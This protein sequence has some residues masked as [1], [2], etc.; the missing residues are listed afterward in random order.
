MITGVDENNPL[1]SQEGFAP[2]GV[3]R[4]VADMREAI[5]LINSRIGIVA[6]IDSH[7]KSA[8]ENF[9]EQVL[10]TRIDDGRHGTGCFFGT[11]FGG[12]RGAGSGNPALD[13]DMV[14]GYLIWKTIYRSY[15]ELPPAN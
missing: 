6:C 12:D 13:E 9:I 5:E 7:D 11:K 15:D 4:S 14:N 1:Y 2:A 10:R 8:T 3:I